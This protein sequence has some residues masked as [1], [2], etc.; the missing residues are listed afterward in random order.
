MRSSDALISVIVP[1]LNEEGLIGDFLRHVRSLDERLEIVV[2]D[3]GSSDRSVSIAKTIADRVI[4]APRGR[5]SQM[6]AGAALASGETLWFLH[7]DLKPAHNSISQ[8]T[9]ILANSH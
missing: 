5:A 2:V 3:G 8:L 1:I 9:A 7:A 4:T 6:N